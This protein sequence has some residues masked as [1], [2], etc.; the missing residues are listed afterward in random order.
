MKNEFLQGL[1]DGLIQAKLDDGR[2]RH[3]IMPTQFILRSLSWKGRRREEISPV[4][5]GASSTGFARYPITQGSP[6]HSVSSTVLPPLELT[7]LVDGFDTG[8]LGVGCVQQ[9]VKKILL[10]SSVRCQEKRLREGSQGEVRIGVKML[11]LPTPFSPPEL[12]SPDGI[13]PL[14]LRVQPP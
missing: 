9:D 5:S 2:G 6:Q 7:G 1:S 8:A 10:A 13:R 11:H 14:R 3:W 12:H 4:E